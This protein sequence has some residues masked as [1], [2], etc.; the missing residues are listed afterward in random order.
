MS[1][2]VLDLAL[3]IDKMLASKQD[4][5]GWVTFNNPTR[6]NAV[7][8]EMWEAVVTIFEAFEKD[9]DIRVVVMKGAG[10]KAFVSGAD[11]SQFEAMRNNAEAAE[12]YS[13][14]SKRGRAAMARLGKPLIAMIRG[15][16][17][18]GG[19]ST[20]L[21]ADIRFASE[22]SQFGIPAARLGLSYSFD[23]L[24]PLAEL[25]NSSVAKDMLFTGR[26]LTAAEALRVGLVNTVVPADQLEQAVRDYAAIIVENAPLTVKAAKFT[27][28]EVVKDPEHRDLEQAERLNRQCMDSQDYAEGRRAFMEKRQPVFLGR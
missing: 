6:R 13:Q 3:G 19:M 10:D 26:R 20:A 1:E 9:P 11:I 28:S 23:S 5:V 15:Y 16:C 14:Y 17:I 2:Q 22:D 8:P 4:G 21:A 24:R 25:V 27:L 12:I 18:G 7:S